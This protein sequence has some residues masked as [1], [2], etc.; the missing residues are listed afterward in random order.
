MGRM[1]WELMA[2]IAVLTTSKCLPGKRPSSKASKT[3]L[4]PNSG[5]GSPNAADSP[6]TKTRI[7]SGGLIF[8][9][10][11]GNGSRAISGPKKRQPN[12][13]LSIM[14]SFPLIFMGRKKDIGCPTPTRRKPISRNKRSSSGPTTIAARR[15]SQRRAWD[16]DTGETFADGGGEDE[17]LERDGFISDSASLYVA[18]GIST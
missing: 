18:P 1:T 4:R 13:S 17:R 15:K 8:G 14:Q 11:L 6:K 3:R 7:V 5:C 10:T 9:M 12:L 2:V 16:T